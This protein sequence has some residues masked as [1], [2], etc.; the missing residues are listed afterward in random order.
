MPSQSI[1]ASAVYYEALD[2]APDLSVCIQDANGPIN[3]TGATV[4]IDIAYGRYNYYYSPTKKIVA[5]GA[6]VV[7][8]DQVTNKGVVHWTPQ[9]GDLQPPGVM[10]YRFKVE[11]PSGGIAHYPPNTKLP[12][13]IRTPIGGWGEAVNGAP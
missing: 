4:T 2:T 12:L 6:C 1:A 13:I 5:D 3:L 9:T 10:H 8:A 7:D 11:Y